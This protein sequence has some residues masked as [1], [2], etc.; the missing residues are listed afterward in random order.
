VDSAD[1]LGRALEAFE[2]AADETGLP[3]VFP[4]HPRTAK[5]L[6]RFGLQKRA[7][8]VRA[9]RQ[10]E[11][12]GYLD[13]L[14]L[15]KNAALVLTDSGGLQEESCFLHVPCVTLRENTE[16]P[17]TLG[18]GANVLAGTDPARV[19][20][21]VRRQ[22]AESRTWANPFGDGTTSAQIARTV[23]KELG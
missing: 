19:R 2:A 13:M 21:A 17:E 3:I 10:I 9:L 23:S 1:R 5:N 7:A 6:A 12:T 18:I 8:S 20:A 22:S 16:R 14:L 15:E 4:I 11:P